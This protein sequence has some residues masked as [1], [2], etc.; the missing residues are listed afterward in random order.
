MLRY[1]YR[2]Y[3][4]PNSGDHFAYGQEIIY[5]GERLYFRARVPG[6]HLWIFVVNEA[7]QLTTLDLGYYRTWQALPIKHAEVAR[8]IYKG[9]RTG[10]SD[11]ASTTFVDEVHKITPDLVRNVLAQETL[12]RTVGVAA[13][14]LPYRTPDGIPIDE[15]PVGPDEWNPTQEELDEVMHAKRHWP[16]VLYSN[17]SEALEAFSSTR[18]PVKDQ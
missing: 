12:A 16:L 8:T 14:A 5:R 17:R 18:K 2:R 4:T 11:L 6:T 10:V 3:N 1:N 13:T 9:R 15:E 7:G